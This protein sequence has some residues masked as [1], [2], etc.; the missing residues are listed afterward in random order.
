MR[1]LHEQEPSPDEFYDRELLI[2]AE[3]E[4]E[5]ELTQRVLATKIGIALGLTNFLLR[6]LA[7]RGYIRVSHAGWKRRLYAL[8]PEGIS[9][10]LQLTASY[11]RRVLS[12]YQSVRQTLREELEPLALNEES[13][14]ALYGPNEFAELVYLGLKEMRIEEIDI[15][16]PDCKPQMRFLGM[17][18][19]DSTL[20]RPGNY[21]KV[22]VAILGDYETTR[23]TLRKQGFS[24]DELVTFF[25]NGKVDNAAKG[26]E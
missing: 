22:V 15:Y 10:K 13:C 9:R 17:P 3:V 21:D 24:D 16:S 26:D 5:P 1:S 7:Q 6:N 25:S 19:R 4:N 14:V 8:T 12:H 18:V 23:K 2:L 11:I 20:L